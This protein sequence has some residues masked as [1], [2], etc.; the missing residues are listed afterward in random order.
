MDGLCGPGETPD[1]L[2]VLMTGAADGSEVS[3]EEFHLGRTPAP[4]CNQDAIELDRT[5]VGQC[6]HALRIRP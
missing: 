1:D 5:A 2:L 3:L 6:Q 4:C